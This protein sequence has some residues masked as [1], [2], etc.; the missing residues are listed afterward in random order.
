MQSIQIDGTYTYAHNIKNLKMGEKIKLV[1]N[2]S[3]RLNSNAIGAYTLDGKKIGY[4]PF[5]KNQIDLNGKY[6]VSKMSLTQLNTQ[7]FISRDFDNSNFIHCENPLVSQIKKTKLSFIDIPE[8]LVQ[9]LRKFYTFLQ[10]AGYDIVK[11]GICEFN[12]CN[13]TIC[14]QTTESKEIFYLVTKKY[15]DENIFKYDEFFK[16]KIINKNIY[17]PFQIHR[18]EKYLEM[19]YNPIE[20]IIKKKSINFKKLIK[21]NMFLLNDLGKN[22]GDLPF[23]KIQTLEDLPF[24]KIQAN[25]LVLFP[26]DSTF[27]TSKLINHVPTNIREQLVKMIIQFKLSNDPIYNPN[28]LLDPLDIKCET[29]ETKINL[30]Y[31]SELFVDIKVGGCGYN[32]N[33]QLYSH[34]DLIDLNGIIDIT[35]GEQISEKYFV[36]LLIKLLIANKQII[37]IYNPVIG[38]IHRIEIS[39]R[40]KDNLI[41]ILM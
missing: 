6:F 3:N 35:I 23:D 32:H 8:D 34:I 7:L 11:I 26:N 37:N 16:F 29:C 38:L 21:Q 24:D 9:D 1:P 30:Q 17:V 20:K 31:F 22:L 36:E 33:L 12:D 19:S 25:E 10:N 28:N 40:V 13:L 15:Y 41:K 2:L 5:R 4:V 39:D 18:L 14:I 27:K